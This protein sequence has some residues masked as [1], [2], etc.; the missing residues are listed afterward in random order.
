MK[1]LKN[2]LLVNA[3]SSGATGILLIAIPG[4]ITHIFNVN[5]RWP[6]IA[7]GIFLFAFALLVFYASYQQVQ[8]ASLVKTI[9]FLDIS[10]VVMSMV[11]VVSQSFGLSMTGYLL[12]TAVA[13]WVAL[14]AYLQHTNLKKSFIEAV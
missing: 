6:F 12:I 10:W 5:Q 2:V 9:I 11:I 3:L 1:T 8:A 7:T 4:M 13:G 14:M